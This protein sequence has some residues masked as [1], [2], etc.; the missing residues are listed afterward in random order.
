[1]SEEN[2]FHLAFY[3]KLT[4]ITTFCQISIR[5]HINKQSSAITTE[6]AA[7]WRVVGGRLLGGL[8]YPPSRQHKGDT[9]S[10]RLRPVKPGCFLENKL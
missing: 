10:L 4:V 2:N 1:M 6:L 8:I 7:E 3:N 9:L 5:P